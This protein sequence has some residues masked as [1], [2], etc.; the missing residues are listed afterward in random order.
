MSTDNI[1][2]ITD[3]LGDLLQPPYRRLTDLCTE[4]NITHLVL[5]V[6]AALPWYYSWPLAVAAPLAQSRRAVAAIAGLSTWVM[7]IFKPD[8]SHGM[9]S[10]LHFSLATA[11]ALAAWYALYRTPEPPKPQPAEPESV[12]TP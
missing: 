9:Y 1:L 8:G 7:V 11:C 10:W 5:F 3:L 4:K 12:S 2:L 6:P